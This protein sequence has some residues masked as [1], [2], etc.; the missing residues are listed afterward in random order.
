[1]ECGSR[2]TQSGQMMSVRRTALPSQL[3]TCG[4]SS[5]SPT[6]G[7]LHACTWNV[8]LPETS[9]STS[10]AGHCGAICQGICNLIQ[11]L[12]GHLAGAEGADSPCLCARRARRA[13][14]SARASRAAS[15]S[16]A[17][18]CSVD[19]YSGDIQHHLMPPL[20][21]YINAR[22]SMLKPHLCQEICV[23]PWH[24]G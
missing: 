7:P 16:S 6:G 4:T 10:Q 3:T 12:V 14:S 15:R 18:A 2:T 5:R 13:S 9:A 11:G 24:Q 19:R 17:L 22:H 8:E 1:M 21:L 20:C 23:K